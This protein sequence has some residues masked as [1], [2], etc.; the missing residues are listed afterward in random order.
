MTKHEYE[1]EFYNVQQE[2]MQI[3]DG[4]MLKNQKDRTLLYGY[5][6]DRL[7]WHV[8]I[9]DGVIHKVKYGYGW[10]S[11]EYMPVTEF[12]VEYNA[13]YVPDK[14]LYPECCDLEFC[15][16][17]E[18]RGVELPFTTFNFDREEKQFY[19]EIL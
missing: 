19:G 10:C 6:C 16:L 4:S 13:Q 8:Y 12:L 9:K 7:T 15:E 5:T 17:L 18:W 14:R 1:I 2:R 3:I 11:N